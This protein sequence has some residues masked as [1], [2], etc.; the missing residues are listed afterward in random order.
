MEKGHSQDGPSPG[1]YPTRILKPPKPWDWISLKSAAIWAGIATSLSSCWLLPS[2]SLS[3][4]RPTRLLLLLLSRHP[5]Q[6]L[7]YRLRLLPPSSPRLP[8]QAPHPPQ[9]Q[10]CHLP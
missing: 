8:G 1:A 10:H 5:R 6:Y 7:S 2:W 9:C 4:C 3:V